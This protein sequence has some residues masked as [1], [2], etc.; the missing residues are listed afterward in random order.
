MVTPSG[1]IKLLDF[2]LAKLIELPTSESDTT[3]TLTKP[4]QL[5]SE[6]GAIIGTIP[7]MSP[8]QA[9]GVPL[10]SRSDIFSF[11]I[12]LYEMMS[13]VIHSAAN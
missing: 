9:E 3:Q 6:Q 2:G 8:E 11:G 5:L 13:G 10:D 12:I 4:R 1:S 7:Y